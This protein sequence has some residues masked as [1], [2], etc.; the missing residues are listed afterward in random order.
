[1][2]DPF[3]DRE[4]LLTIFGAFR[5][6]LLSTRQCLYKEFVQSG[7]IQKFPKRQ[8]KTPKV[9]FAAPHQLLTLS[10]A[11]AVTYAAALEATRPKK[12]LVWVSKNHWPLV[13]LFRFLLVFAWV[14]LSLCLGPAPLLGFCLLL[15]GTCSCRSWST[16]F[17]TTC[18]GQ[19]CFEAHMA[20]AVPKLADDLHRSSLRRLV[21]S[22]G[23]AK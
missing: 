21:L 11:N 19:A 3:S 22:P 7:I 23:V 1:M 14:L 17:G 13:L 18:V 6:P 9:H 4:T 12:T 10:E 5:V 16:A 20:S 15:N 8:R 2:L